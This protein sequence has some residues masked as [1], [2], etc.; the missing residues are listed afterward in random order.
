MTFHLQTDKEPFRFHI[1]C[2]GMN[3]LKP[4]AVT[5]SKEEI[6]AIRHVYIDLDNS[7]GKAVQAI[8]NCNSLPKASF[9][10]T[11]SPDKFQVA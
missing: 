1:I 5:R 7:G 2:I 11:S 10:L 9:E 8:H 4:D 3:P 6:D